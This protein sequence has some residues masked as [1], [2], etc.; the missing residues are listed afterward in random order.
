MLEVAAEIPKGARLGRAGCPAQGWGERQC[1][2][3]RE[4][5]GTLKPVWR[6]VPGG[7]RC[8]ESYTGPPLL[9]GLTPS[10][11][12]TLL[13][14]VRTAASLFRP[15]IPAGPGIGGGTTAVCYSVPLIFPFS[16]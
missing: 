8:E 4:C 14:G 7:L 2:S 15:A 3:E 13:V 12:L 6:G 16:K 9:P 11:A 1:G 5:V 10:E